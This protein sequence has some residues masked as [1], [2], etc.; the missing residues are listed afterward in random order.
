MEVVVV[1]LVLE[2]GVGL[3]V[4]VVRVAFEWGVGLEGLGQFLHT[5]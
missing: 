2:W 5:F 3:E 4:L 1:R